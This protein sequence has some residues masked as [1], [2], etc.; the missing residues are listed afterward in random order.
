MFVITAEDVGGEGMR[1]LEH[2]VVVVLVMDD[3]VV[4]PWTG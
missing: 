1:L 3:D 4:R 2:V